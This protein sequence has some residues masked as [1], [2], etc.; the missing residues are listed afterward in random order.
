M[1]D[2]AASSLLSVLAPD[3][4]PIQGMPSVDDLN[5]LPDMGRMTR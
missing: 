3:A 2:L 4:P 1:H 5:F